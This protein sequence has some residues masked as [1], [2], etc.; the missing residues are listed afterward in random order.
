[1]IEETQHGSASGQQEF[2]SPPPNFRLALIQVRS[3]VLVTHR[4]GRAMSGSVDDLTAF[5]RK[6]WIQNLL[7][8]WWG[9]PFG[10][11]WTPIALYRNSQS[12]RALRKLGADGLAAAGWYPD[13][14]GR[15]GARYWD[16]KAW[17]DR[18]SDTG[19]DSLPAG[20]STGA[21]E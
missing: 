12:L 21:A 1:M 18:V 3:F 10:L 6:V 5:A 8:G 15:H 19:T 9:F 4:R 11:V 13:P 20:V 7:L 17:T 16:G 14:S 2:G